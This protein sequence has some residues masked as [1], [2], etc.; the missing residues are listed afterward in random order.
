MSDARLRELERQAAAGDADARARLLLERERLGHFTRE[1]LALA[2]HAGDPVARRALDLPAQDGLD[3]LAWARGFYAFGQHACVRGVAA[4]V[5]ASLDRRPR[6]PRATAPLDALRP[7][8]A[9]PC[10]E[11]AAPVVRL[12][13]RTPM[14]PS[15]RPG[16]L[17]GVEWDRG[18]AAVLR[19][20]PTREEI[21]RARPPLEQAGG[22]TDVV[23]AAGG[24]FAL[25]LRECATVVHKIALIKEVRA[26]SGFNLAESV[27]AVESVNAV[28][29]AITDLATALGADA[30][31]AREVIG[32]TLIAW[33]L[34][35]ASR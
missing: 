12:A 2:A 8:L 9:C 29:R 11:H 30:G 31:A 17:L 35:P 16:L 13:R 23:P 27:S 20:S 1:R 26:A 24:G 32:Q 21:E 33:A 10:A 19:S 18:P 22:V 28:P 6:P 25:R 4:A 34:D 15:S 7:W 3:L 14:E 5:Q